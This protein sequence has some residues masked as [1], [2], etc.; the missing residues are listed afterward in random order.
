M[1]KT[2]SARNTL[3]PNLDDIS[4]TL[5]KIREAVSEETSERAAAQ[6]DNIER[7]MA[8]AANPIEEAVAPSSVAGQFAAMMAGTN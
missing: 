6:P 7:D 2:S 8:R 3:Q 4:L 1:E 5:D